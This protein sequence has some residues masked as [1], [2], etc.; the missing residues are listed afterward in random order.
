[1][2]LAYCR[3]GAENLL[4]KLHKDYELHPEVS[5]SK[6]FKIAEFDCGTGVWLI[7]LASHHPPRGWWPENMTLNVVDDAR[8]DLPF[9]LLGQYDEVHLRILT[10]NLHGGK[11]DTGGGSPLRLLIEAAMEIR[12]CRFGY[13]CPVMELSLT[14][15]LQHNLP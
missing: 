12:G 11:A 6:G 5:I 15:A 1:M 9:S 8:I 4:W 3:A 14:A 10:S 7:D 13:W 2:C